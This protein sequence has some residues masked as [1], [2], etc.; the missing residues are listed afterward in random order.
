MS[1]NMFATTTKNNGADGVMKIST[2]DQISAR[3][4]SRQLVCFEMPEGVDHAAMIK[5]LQEGLDNVVKKLPFLK[6]EVVPC[7]PETHQKGRLEVRVDMSVKHVEL[8]VNDL[9]QGPNRVPWTYAELKQEGFPFSMM[10]PEI[11]LPV[12]FAPK[13]NDEVNRVMYSQVN[14]VPGGIILGSGF[15]HCV[16]DAGGILVLIHM[17]AHYCRK[18]LWGFPL[19]SASFD[20]TLLTLGDPAASDSPPASLPGSPTKKPVADKTPTDI[21]DLTITDSSDESDG[22]GGSGG[23]DES[24]ATPI[25]IALGGEAD[26]PDTSKLLVQALEA[27]ATEGQEETGTEAAHVTDPGLIAPEITA[28]ERPAKVTAPTST[29]TPFGPTRTSIFTMTA[30]KVAELK[31]LCNPKHA[32]SPVEA[33]VFITT[34]DALTALMWHCIVTTRT[35]DELDPDLDVAE[36]RMLVD[37]RTRV[38]PALPITY[39]GNASIGFMTTVP[40]DMIRATTPSTL[41]D[42]ALAVRNGTNSVD[43]A[44]VRALMASVECLADV[45]D[46]M[47]NATALSRAGIVIASWAKMPIYSLEWGKVLGT[48]QRVRHARNDM[49]DARCIIL[50]PLADGTFE[51]VVGLDEVHMTRLIKH[52]TFRAFGVWK[53]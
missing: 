35:A 32:S 24:D 41:A 8:V 38:K 14:L 45:N 42:V 22:S 48:P 6:G 17:W 20:R 25:L 49:M 3:F 34:N 36:L 43:D 2:I 12:D 21:A 50:P 15:H 23:S 37:T 11:L 53:C 27:T 16:F 19:A 10:D 52:D 29:L 47:K 39:L 5:T 44:Y 7:G 51:I 46:R 18:P 1:I 31:E 30:E 33:G 13:T 26:R 9:T 28:T 4:Y 40:L